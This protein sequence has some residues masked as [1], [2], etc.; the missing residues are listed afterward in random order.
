MGLVRWDPFKDMLFIQ[1]RMSRM[2]DEAFSQMRG[3]GPF[4]PGS[5]AWFPP[6]DIYETEDDIVL[7]AELPGVRVE[8]VSVEANENI[9][10]LKGERR[11]EKDLA[12][13][14]C[15][16]MERFYGPFQ[17]VFCLPNAIEKDS[18]RAGFKDGVLEITVPKAG[19]I[20]QRR[21]MIRVD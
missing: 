5:G 19:A 14:N 2:F 3:S 9:L 6:V 21:V 20:R 11:L 16:R 13:E 12:S 4:F 1:D 10:T 8:D 17:R 15:H 18:I 7:K